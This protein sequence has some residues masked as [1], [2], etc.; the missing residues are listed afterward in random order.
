MAKVPDNYTLFAASLLLSYGGIAD[1]TDNLAQ[2]FRRR[3]RLRGVVTPYPGHMVRDY[4]VKIFD[5][6]PDRRPTHFDKWKIGSKIMTFFYFVRLYISSCRELKKLGLHKKNEYLIFTEYYTVH[7]DIIIFCARLLNIK[8]AIVFH[9]LD[10][11]C[12]RK[13]QFMHFNR[14]FRK[15][16]FIIYNSEATRK[17]A[18]DLHGVNH[19]RTMILWPGIDVAALEKYRSPENTKTFF[20]RHRKEIIFATVARL[21]RRKGIDLAI[22][23]VCEL[24]KSNREIRYYIAGTGEED[25][26]LKALVKELKG[27]EFIFF[28]GD[29]SN[30]EKYALLEASDIFLFS[31]HSSGNNDFEGFGISCIEAS[32]FGNVIIG[33]HHGGVKEA[34]LEGKTGFL[35][36]FD[37]PQSLEE[38]LATIKKC[39]DDPELIERIKMQGNKYVKAMYDWNQLIQQFTKAEQELFIA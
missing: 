3:K 14:N 30:E 20:K 39:I 18:S 33:G 6:E 31:N 7:F 1:Y 2:Q 16:E 26:K 15:A 13:H 9:G 22:R 29:I 28:L 12:A 19:K 34:V 10:L 27:E 4:D 11:I 38:A 17:L 32:F 35:F 37:D 25:I 24:A 5:I 21:V 8:Y 36:D 23:M